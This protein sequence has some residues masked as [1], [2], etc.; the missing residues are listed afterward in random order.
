MEGGLLLVSIGLALLLLEVAW[1]FM[2]FGTDTFSF[3][4]MD[5]LHPIGE[6]GLLQPSPDPGVVYELRPGVDQLFKRVPFRTN[7]HGLRDDPYPYRKPAGTVRVAVIGDSY[8]M[9]SG[10]RIEDAFHSILERR[11][12]E[13]DPNHP[14]EFLNF[15]VGGYS[16]RHYVAVLRQKAIRYEP[17][18]AI[19]AFC[20]DNDQQVVGPDYASRPVTVR[21]RRGAYFHS[22][23]REFLQNLRAA[24]RHAPGISERQAAYLDEVFAELA[25]ASRAVNIPVVVAY[26]GNQPDHP[27]VVA[28][29]ARAHG[30]AWV[31]ASEGLAGTNLQ[32][33]SIYYPLDT[34]P[35]AA[36]HAIFADAIYKYLRAKGFPP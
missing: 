14:V 11:F 18:L 24:R 32:D 17:D 12:T 26:L 36:A 25:A 8:T 27:E 16:L 20:A 33:F 35:N 28:A 19:I 1:R 34:H 30:L 9:A 6:A 31:N 21:P 5:S 2:V 7:A 22:H 3:R 4:M 15:G 13:E 10:V 23:L 29:A